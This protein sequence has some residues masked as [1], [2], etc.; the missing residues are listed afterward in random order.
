LNLLFLIASALAF[1]SSVSFANFIS[2]ERSATKM[3]KSGQC[4]SQSLQPMQESG[5]TTSIVLPCV[6][7]TFCTIAKVPDGHKLTHISQALHLDISTQTNALFPDWVK[8]LIRFSPYYLTFVLQKM[9]ES[10]S[11]V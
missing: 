7:F 6:E 8:K 9:A 1:D 10:I 3:A 11:V 5:S 2:P 4:N